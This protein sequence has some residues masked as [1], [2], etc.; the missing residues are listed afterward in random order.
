MIITTLYLNERCPDAHRDF[1]DPTQMHKTVSRLASGD[2][3]PLF[4]I[5]DTTVRIQ[6]E[7]PIDVATL[8]DVYLIG[9]SARGVVMPSEGDMIEIRLR[10][11]PNVQRSIRGGATTDRRVRNLVGEI[12]QLTWLGSRLCRVGALVMDARI[13]SRRWVIAE[14]KN[15]AAARIYAVDYRALLRITDAITFAEAMRRGIG[16]GK[17]FGLGMTYMEA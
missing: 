7:R 8:P 9:S 11:N 15:A 4:R 2:A 1:T 17:A 16:R 14:R 5:D 13:V 6:T 10:A 3:R 12:P